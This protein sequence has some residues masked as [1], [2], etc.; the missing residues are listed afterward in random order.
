M[1]THL[2]AYQQ[3]V[4]P[5]TLTEINAL[6][7]DVLTRVEAT[8]YL[9]PAEVPNVIWA[10]GV[11][12]KLL[13]AMLYSPSIEVRRM[14]PY[15]MPLNSGAAVF[16]LNV[17]KIF[18]PSPPITLVPTEALSAKIIASD[19][20]PASNVVLVCLGPAALP[21]MPAGEIRRV[22]CTSSTTLTP[23]V[24]T[25]VKI[26]PDI[27]LE[28]GTYA[29]VNFYAYS[30]NAI[31]ARVLISGQVWRPGLPALSGDS[32]DAALRFNPKIFEL[33]SFYEMGRFTH[34]TIP[35]FQFLSAAADTSEVVYL[36]LIKVG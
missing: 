6:V 16:D 32:E 25:S 1:A 10:A 21:P 36:D 9:V 19:A 13:K 17:A 3:T 22:R 7:D 4:A 18:K 11:G 23:N 28:A 8:R 34:M 14:Q 30:A 26:V 24:W 2:I 35:E 15:I 33:T 27:A 31:A 12:S 29:L 5:A 20:T